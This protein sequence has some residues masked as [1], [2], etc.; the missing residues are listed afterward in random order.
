MCSVALGVLFLAFLF[1]IVTAA[2]LCTGPIPVHS[3]DPKNNYN[4]TPGK[5]EN[6]RKA[7]DLRNLLG[8]AS[9]TSSLTH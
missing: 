4:R 8:S 3:C 9:R 2:G 6:V 7:N 1:G 5:G